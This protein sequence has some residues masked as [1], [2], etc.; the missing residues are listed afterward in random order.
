MSFLFKLSH[1]FSTLLSN[2]AQLQSRL[3]SRSVQTSG[4]KNS[5][6]V[7]YFLKN[8]CQNTPS[9]LHG[10]WKDLVTHFK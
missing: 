3:C 10:V 7:S 6:S 1:P 4:L 2:V 8:L 5:G 9:Q